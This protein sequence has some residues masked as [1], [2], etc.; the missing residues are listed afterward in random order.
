VVNVEV[1]GTVADPAL[2]HR[3]VERDKPPSLER[4]ASDRLAAKANYSRRAA[5]RR[6]EIRPIVLEDE[7]DERGRPL[8]S[9]AMRY[10]EDAT[11]ID[12]ADL[13][14]EAGSTPHGGQPKTTRAVELLAD[15]LAD[16]EWHDS[17]GLKTLIGAHGISE[18]TVKRAAQALGVESERRGFPAATWW[19]R[20][21]GHSAH[22]L[23]PTGEPTGLDTANPHEQ[24]VFDGFGAPVGPV[25]SVGSGQ[26]KRDPTGPGDPVYCSRCEAR[27]RVVR[28]DAGG[29]RLA[30]GHAPG[31]AP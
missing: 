6:Y 22:G 11:G 27:K 19:R 3:C 17:A 23:S 21:S 26:G 7:L 1:V 25:G 8:E 18:P 29:V 24:A 10:V 15:L 2:V 31:E 5:P 13:L 28:I 20:G 14:A 4:R 9:S 16:G 30:C 12:L